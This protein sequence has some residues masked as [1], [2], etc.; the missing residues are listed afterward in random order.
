MKK[1]II[2]NVL[3]LATL[4]SMCFLTGYTITYTAEAVAE[5]TE[6]IALATDYETGQTKVADE[7]E[8]IV[9][10]YKEWKERWEGKNKEK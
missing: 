1:R 10:L 6:T 8:E 5:D 9:A 7:K 4:F 2:A 3:T